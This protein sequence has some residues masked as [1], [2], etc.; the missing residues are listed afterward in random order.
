[1]PRPCQWLT[2]VQREESSSFLWFRTTTERAFRSSYS[3]FIFLLK[4]KICYLQLLNKIISDEYSTGHQTILLSLYIFLD[5][6]SSRTID[7]KLMMTYPHRGSLYKKMILQ[8]KHNLNDIGKC[9]GPTAQNFSKKM[10]IQNILGYGSCTGVIEQCMSSFVIFRA[11][12]GQ[13]I[14]HPSIIRTPDWILVH[15]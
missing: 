7:Q 8:V 10:S 13:G 1:M 11:I 15:L 6:W 2:K 5:Q 3:N 12:I 9:C 4:W 14:A